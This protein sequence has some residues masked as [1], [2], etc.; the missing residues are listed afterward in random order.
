MAGST[1]SRI[2]TWIAGQTLTASDL[3]AEFDNVLSNLDPTGI[4]DESASNAAAQ[5]VKD[6]YSGASLDKAVSLEEELQ[7]L[8]Y[9]IKQLHGET[10]W[11]VDPGTTD[12][13]AKTALGITQGAKNLLINPQGE[14][15]QRGAS[16]SATFD[17]TTNTLNSDNTYLDDRW[18][19]LSDG[20]DVVDV[21]QQTG[22]GVSGKE[23]YIRYDVETA[24][25]K[26]GRFQII[27]NKNCKC[28]L[29]DVAS[30]S[31]ESNVTNATKLSDIRMA[32]F[33]W[34]STADS[35]TSDLVATWEAEGTII[36]PATNWTAEN[37][38]ANLS[39]TT[40]WVKYKVENISIDTASAANVGVFVY[41]NNVATNDTT[42]VFLEITNAQLEPGAVSTDFEYRGVGHE[43]RLC[44]RYYCKSYDLGVVPGAIDDNGS[45]NFY[46]DGVTNADH[47]VH[48]DVRFPVSMRANPTTAVF[49]NTS[50]DSGKVTM[51]NGDVVGGASFI[52]DGGFKCVGENGAIATQ[53]RLIFHYKADAEL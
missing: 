46:V 39:V 14:H 5:A 12:G 34:D 4:D 53:R 18:L 24:Q 16:G 10:Y 15:A 23:P 31:V 30:V 29:G 21:T 41:Q 49:S 28:I 2:K 26:F 20:N 33:S 1:F 25:K 11:Y 47:F 48:F 7:Q 3:N 9:L 45:I 50:G 51:M 38:A 52:S 13:L 43:L 32:V 19:L 17:A 44:Q 22:G 27:E 37:V 35:V 42:G 6:P 40:S 8:R 36:T